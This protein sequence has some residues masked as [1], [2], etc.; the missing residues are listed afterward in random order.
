MR[1]YQ[2]QIFNNTICYIATEYKKRAR[3]PLFQTM[4]YKI[5]A[6]YDFRVLREMGRPA[7]EIEY[8]AMDR[9]P[10]PTQLYN[11]EIKNDKF[12]MT[13]GDGNKVTV[14][15]VG[16]A[17]LDYISEKEREILDGVIE[18]LGEANAQ[19]ASDASH[20]DIRSWK[21]KY[22]QNRNGIMDYAD[23]FAENINAKSESELTDAERNFLNY[24]FVKDL[25][26]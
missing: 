2:E 14:E 21:K 19:M 1:A 18:I 26:Q 5:M 25:S 24:Q 3:R 23:E 17:D 9:G 4:L 15:A 20:E 22:D 11:K 13:K 8:K 10:V 7:L 12:K 16:K 6:M